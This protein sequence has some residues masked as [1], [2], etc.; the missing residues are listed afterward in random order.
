[1]KN[2][3]QLVINNGDNEYAIEHFNPIFVKNALKGEL[4]PDQYMLS[5][6]YSHAYL[7]K[8]KNG[9]Y[10]NMKTKITDIFLEFFLKNIQNFF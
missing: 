4:L 8:N 5:S 7:T 10:I 9:G 3:F 1:M 6:N 2:I